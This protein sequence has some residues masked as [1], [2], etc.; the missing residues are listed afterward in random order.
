LVSQVVAVKLIASELSRAER[1]YFFGELRRARAA[2]LL[3][4]EDYLTIIITLE[5]L[6]GILEPGARGLGKLKNALLSIAELAG[7]NPVSSAIQQRVPAAKLFDL[8]KDGRNGAVHYGA[9][10]RHLARHCVEFALLIE[11]GLMADNNNISDF[12]IQDPV[13]AEPWQQI[14]LVRH[15]MLLNAFSSLPIRFDNKWRIVWDHEIVSCMAKSGDPRDALSKRIEDVV[16]DGTLQLSEASTV[17]PDA[18][19]RDVALLARQG[20]TLVVQDDRLLGIVTPFD[21][22]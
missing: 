18:A 21:L 12:M 3:D 22:L 11:A 10:A 15:K 13:C 17:G 7:V 4:A 6:G 5:R 1:R 8:M 2:A 19:K 9:Q 16:G 14:G 20:P